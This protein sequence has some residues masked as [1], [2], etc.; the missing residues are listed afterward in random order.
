MPTTAINALRYPAGGVSPNIPQDIQN[1]AQDVD[2]KLPKPGAWTSY[3]PTWTCQ[4]SIAPAV[5]NGSLIGMYIKVGRLVAFQ[6]TMSFGSTTNA[7]SGAFV[8]GLPFQSA[9][10]REQRV[11]C[12]A[13]AAGPRMWSG[14]ATI[15]GSATTCVPYLPFSSSDCGLSTAQSSNSAQTLGTG[16]PARSGNFSFVTGENITIHGVYEAAS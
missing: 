2:A 7:G 1:L 5:G 16:V 3:T 13:Y 11:P 14:V 4:G 10:G 8:F 15:F 12:S 9:A 6:V